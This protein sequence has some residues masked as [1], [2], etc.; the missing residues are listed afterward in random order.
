MINNCLT[1]QP[2]HYTYIG[3]FIATTLNQPTLPIK[4]TT[5]KIEKDIICQ[6]IV[7]RDSI[8]V[9][10][11]FLP[12]SN[13]LSSK[14]KR[15]IIKSKQKTSIEENNLRNVTIINLSNFDKK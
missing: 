1:F 7:K 10:T 6:K 9:I 5:I 4:I 3:V 12:V 2:S 14:K 15:Q 11:N 13:M 8:K